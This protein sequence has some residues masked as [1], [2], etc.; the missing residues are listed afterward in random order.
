MVT[1]VLVGISEPP[2]NLNIAGGSGGVPPLPFDKAK[3][4][5]DSALH[6]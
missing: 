4:I 2:P 1:W 6:S 5:S 3:L